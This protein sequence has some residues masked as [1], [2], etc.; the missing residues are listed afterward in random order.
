MVSVQVADKDVVDA[1]HRDFQPAHCIWVPSAQSSRNHLLWKRRAWA[2]VWRRE[3]G[4][5]AELPSTWTSNVLY[6]R[7]YAGF[8]AHNCL[9]SA[10]CRPLPSASVGKHVDDPEIPVNQNQVGIPALLDA[11]LC[12]EFQ[13]VCHIGGDY[14]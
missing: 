5:A 10:F 13:D 12:S 14:F 3:V 6:T 8:T 9:F 7:L 1:H 11:A 2:V 4:V